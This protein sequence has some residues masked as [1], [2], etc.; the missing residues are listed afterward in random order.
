MAVFKDS[1]LSL[2]ACFS[3]VTSAFSLEWIPG[4]MINVS[5]KSSSVR[6][7]FFIPSYVFADMLMDEWKILRSQGND[8]SH[9]N[10][11]KNNN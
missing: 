7:C 9:N 5:A 2:I 6:T 1:H 10:D 11:N 4:S 3:L 8:T